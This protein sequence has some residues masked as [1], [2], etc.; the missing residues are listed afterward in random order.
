MKR[1][2]IFEIKNGN[3]LYRDEIEF[4]T[5]I[6]EIFWKLKMK[7]KGRKVREFISEHIL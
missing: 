4:K 2:K 5:A 1:R 3:I 7:R 6:H